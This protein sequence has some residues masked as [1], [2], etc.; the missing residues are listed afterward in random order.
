MR[1]YTALDGTCLDLDHVIAVGPAITEDYSYEPPN[2]FVVNCA[3]G[4]KVYIG[5]HDGADISVEQMR[6][7]LLNAWA[8][9]KPKF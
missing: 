7:H 2:Y 4:S 3:F 5:A 9:G 1:F 6:N 8:P